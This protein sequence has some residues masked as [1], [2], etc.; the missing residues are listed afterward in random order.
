[1]LTIINLNSP[2]PPPHDLTLPSKLLHLRAVWCDRMK[3]ELD[4]LAKD[5]S[6]QMGRAPS[7]SQAQQSA[8]VLP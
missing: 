7:N 3:E 1:M 2:F 4:K 6:A 8:C 5:E